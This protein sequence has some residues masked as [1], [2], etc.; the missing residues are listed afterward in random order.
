M[1]PT[2]LETDIVTSRS[3]EID[4]DS[5]DRNWPEDRDK[6]NSSCLYHAYLCW[7]YSYMGSILLKGS[8]RAKQDSGSVEKITQNDLFTTPTS[9]QSS[10]LASKFKNH[11]FSMENKATFS[12]KWKLMI[13]L[14]RLA[15]PTFIP[16]GFCQLITVLCQVALP[17]LVRELL[18]TLEENPGAEVIRTGM[19]CKFI[20]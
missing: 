12:T 2:H 11:F 6:K 4:T 5:Q 20:I 10:Y 16:A 8:Q 19:P 14:W 18:T 15:A 17:L 9:M 3:N 13:T 1:N 7:T